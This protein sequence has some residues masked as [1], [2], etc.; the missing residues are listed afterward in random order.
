MNTYNVIKKSFLSWALVFAMSFAFIA[1]G[2]SRNTPE[3]DESTGNVDIDKLFGEEE[4]TNQS[5]DEDE[6]LRLL[7]IV[8]ESEKPKEGAELA[9]TET[10]AINSEAN[11]DVDNLRSEVEAKK[12]RISQLEATE[13]EKDSKIKQLEEELAK[14]QQRASTNGQRVSLSGSYAQKYQQARNL[15]EQY[16]YNDAIQ[17]FSNLLAES[18]TTKLSDNAQY[19]IGESYY[20]L[21]NYEQA[22]A[23]FEKVFTFARSDKRDDA[24]LKLGLCHIRIGDR[25]QAKS[26]LE[27]LLANFPNSE[28]VAKAKLYLSKL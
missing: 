15:Y 18:S 2:G 7:G 4:Q 19:W 1:C 6:V 21:G 12:Q 11:P 26:E 13:R 22:I 9:T 25:Q 10:S 16:K 27:Q 24:F 14:A 23:E 5:S 8:P 17:A 28:Y 3:Y 20:G